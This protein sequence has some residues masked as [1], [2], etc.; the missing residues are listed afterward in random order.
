MK[1]FNST[2]NVGKGFKPRKAWVKKP[3][4]LKRS[5]LSKLGKSPVAATKRRIQALLRDIVMKRDYGC[6]LRHVRCNR[7]IGDPGVIWQADHLLSR[8]NSATY[9][10][11]RLVVLVCRECHAWK[12]LGSNLR[13]AEYDRL[14]RSILPPE[15]VTLWDMAEIEAGRHKAVKMDWTL[16]ELSLQ[17]E[18]KNLQKVL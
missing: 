4:I 16:V 15:R 1:A 8:S 18:L 9:G 7:R 3:Y 11:S 12:S 14:V 5:T 6:I 10:D 2:L 17:Q 13:K